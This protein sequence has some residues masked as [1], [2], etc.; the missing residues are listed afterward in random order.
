MAI[1]K[2]KVKSKSGKE[3]DVIEADKF[4]VLYITKNGRFHAS[5]KEFEEILKK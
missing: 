3:F 4:K 5:H 2:G 1:E